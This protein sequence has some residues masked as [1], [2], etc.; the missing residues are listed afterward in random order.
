MRA[1]AVGA[2]T[3]QRPDAVVLNLLFGT[4]QGFTLCTSWLRSIF[5][6]S[7]SATPLSSFAKSELLKFAGERCRYLWEDPS[8][9]ASHVLITLVLPAPN[10]PDIATFVI[11]STRNTS[12]SSGS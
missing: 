6:M 5:S 12:L 4:R 8:L 10:G 3:L 9:E 2:T 7:P 1:T 11:P